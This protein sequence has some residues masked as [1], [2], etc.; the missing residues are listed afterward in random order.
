[1]DYHFTTSD[2]FGVMWKITIDMYPKLSVIDDNNYR[3]AI[4]NCSNQQQQDF[5]LQ[6]FLES[7]N[8]QNNNNN[9]NE[10]NK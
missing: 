4:L 2:L 9:Q 10:N 5:I 1:M 8:N 6:Q 3:H 7:K